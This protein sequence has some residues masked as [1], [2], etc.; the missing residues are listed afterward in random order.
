VRVSCNHR[1]RALHLLLAAIAVGSVTSLAAARLSF[2]FDDQALGIPPEGFFFA[3]ARQPAPGTWEV[4]G[5][6]TQR[7]LIHL[8]DPSVTMRGI[9]VAGVSAAAPADVKVSARLR[10]V[11]ADRA[12]GLLWHYKDAA[13]F[14]FLSVFLGVR[15]IALIRVTGGNRV[16][17]DRVMNVDLDPEAWHSLS[18]VHVGNQIVGQVDGIPVVHGRDRTL[19]EGGRAG[20]WSAGNSTTWFDD[21]SIEDHPQ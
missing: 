5:M 6:G 7:H 19:A 12:G 14:Y 8:A 11:D 13:D 16:T 17:L 10:L 4:R 18:V 9:A 21:I 20:V 15:E 3:G 2:T 1:R